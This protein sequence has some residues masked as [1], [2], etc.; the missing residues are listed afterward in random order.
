MT[1][2]IV[3]G[4]VDVVVLRRVGTARPAWRVL[5]LERAIGVRSTGAWEIVHGSIEPNE[6]DRKSV[7]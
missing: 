6:T 1:T 3:A 5:T 2:K 7:V 4:V